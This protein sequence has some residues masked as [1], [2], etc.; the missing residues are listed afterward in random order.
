MLVMWCVSAISMVLPYWG[1]SPRTP[2]A[3][4]W[5]EAQIAPDAAIRAAATLI[6]DRSLV[7][8]SVQLRPLLGAPVYS[9]SFAGGSTVFVDA[10]TGKAFGMD[11]DLARRVAEAARGVDARAAQRIDHH[12]RH[13]ITGDLPVYRVD[14]SD[15]G[16]GAFVSVRT[17]TVVL[18]TWW[19]LLR[20][21]L[22]AAHDGR[23][24]DLLM[25][26]T[27]SRLISLGFSTLIVAATVTGLWLVFP[28]W[29]RNKRVTPMSSA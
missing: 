13:Y 27:A 22:A 26:R 20:Q 15:G 23:V 17:G 29:R 8:D 1:L 25:G 4:D 11:A 7:P 6:D 14:F 2:A 5:R 19:S 9:I 12:G 3:P 21:L 18:T 16:P 10:R 28:I 24:V